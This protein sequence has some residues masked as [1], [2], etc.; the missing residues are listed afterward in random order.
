MDTRE[1]GSSPDDPERE[2]SMAGRVEE[3]LLLAQSRARAA[4]EALSQYDTRVEET[5]FRA[6][7]LLEESRFGDLIVLTCPHHCCHSMYLC[8]SSYFF[9]NTPLFFAR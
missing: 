9:E 3:A 2:T 4:E 6:L 8:I 7:A 5:A 1:H